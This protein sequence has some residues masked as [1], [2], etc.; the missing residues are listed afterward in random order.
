M[1]TGHNSVIE[2]SSTVK[3]CLFSLHRTRISKIVNN[4]QV[5]LMEKMKYSE[6]VYSKHCAIF[7]LLNLKM[8]SKSLE[9]TITALFKCSKI[10]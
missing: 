9:K 10:D 1:W 3:L 2:N 4:L 7:N 6:Y 5:T 8:E